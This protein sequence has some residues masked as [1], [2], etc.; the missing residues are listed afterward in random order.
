VPCFVII[1]FSSSGLY[2]A[3]SDGPYQTYIDYIRALPLNPSPEVFGLHENADIT[4]DNQETQ[5]VN[6]CSCVWIFLFIIFTSLMLIASA[7]LEIRIAYYTFNLL[8]ETNEPSTH[9]SP[10]CR[11]LVNWAESRRMYFILFIDVL[12]NKQVTG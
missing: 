10:C 3:P 12:I 7:F 11:K 1:R 9:A 6:D 5:L 4:K 8:Y 2:F